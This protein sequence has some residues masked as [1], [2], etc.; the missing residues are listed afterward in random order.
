[1]IQL[2]SSQRDLTN[3]LRVG[4]YTFGC[5]GQVGRD[6]APNSQTPLLPQILPS[7]NMRLKTGSKKDECRR[8]ATILCQSHYAPKA[9]KISSIVLLALALNFPSD[10]AQAKKV[11]GATQSS[12]C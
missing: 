7:V 2:S 10:K 11:T 9:T 6:H 1:M 4:G 8:P 3:V 5:M 12:V